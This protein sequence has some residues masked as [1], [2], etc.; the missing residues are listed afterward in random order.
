V[1]VAGAHETPEPHAPNSLPARH[2]PERERCARGLGAPVGEEQARLIVAPARPGIGTVA[3]GQVAHQEL[4]DAAHPW[5]SAS[6]ALRFGQPARLIVETDAPGRVRR[7]GLVTGLGEV[8]RQRVA[9]ATARV[10]ASE[11]VGEA[12]QIAHP[13]VARA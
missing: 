11:Q 7:V 13:H 9:R 5:L 3:N 6:D 12:R 2:E 10:Q 8:E 1:A 4:G